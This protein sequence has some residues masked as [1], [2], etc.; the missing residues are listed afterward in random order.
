MFK[1]QF[2][3]IV[4][5][6]SGVATIDLCGE[7]TALAGPALE[8]AYS[9]AESQKPEV[10]WLNF[11]GVNYLNSTGIAL[12]IGLLARTQ[13]TPCTLMACGLRPFYVELFELAG[14]DNYMPILSAEAN[15]LLP[16]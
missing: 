5:H 3:T 15:Q 9:A 8:A 10:I 14:L 13:Q 4:S 2:E 6:R 1:K 11:A 16:L 7:L 12:I